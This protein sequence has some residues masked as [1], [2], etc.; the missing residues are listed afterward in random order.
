MEKIDFSK[1]NWNEKLEDVSSKENNSQ[2]KNTYETAEN[3]TLKN[4]YQKSVGYF[5][6]YIKYLMLI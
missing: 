2:A 6:D 3:I 1:I 5:L 4:F